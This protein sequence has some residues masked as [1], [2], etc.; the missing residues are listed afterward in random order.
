M[1]LSVWLLLLS[2]IFNPWA[3]LFFVV[4]FCVLF[5]LFLLSLP[6]WSLKSFQYLLRL[7]VLVFVRV[8]SARFP[9]EPSV[10]RGR[11]LRPFCFLLLLFS[12]F[13]YR[14]TLSWNKRK[15]V[16]V[17]TFAILSN[18]CFFADFA[19]NLFSEPIYGLSFFSFAVSLFI[20]LAARLFAPKLYLLKRLNGFWIYS[21]FRFWIWVCMR[22]LM[23]LVKL[24]VTIK[25]S[26]LFLH[27][28][29]IYLFLDGL[30]RGALRSD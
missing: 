25:I 16:D 23:F 20:L 7:L 8:S 6:S 27:Y 22:F 11:I 3:L 13:F 26:L 14:V 9:R 17:R 12:L 18:I 21:L 1:F 10:R 28:K 19:H 29:T 15:E 4:L 5:C 30:K 24:W 2:F